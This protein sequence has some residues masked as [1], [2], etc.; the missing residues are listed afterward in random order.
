MSS[1]RPKAFLPTKPNRP[2]I[3]N[4]WTTKA[5]TYQ[6]LMLGEHGN[7]QMKN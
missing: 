6:I 4:S 7:R 3:T 5:N 2:S 1:A